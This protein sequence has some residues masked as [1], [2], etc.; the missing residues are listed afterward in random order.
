MVFHNPMQR[1]RVLHWLFGLVGLIAPMM[2]A[3]GQDRAEDGSRY[4]FSQE[5]AIPIVISAPHGGAINLKGVE[6]RNGEG[7]PQGASGFFAG[8][9]GGTEELAQEIAKE[10]EKRFG[11]PPFVVVS[12]VHRKYVD[13]NRPADLAYQHEKTKQ[14]Y[15]DYHGK[16]KDF[17]TKISSQYSAGLLLD[18]HGQGTSRETVYRGTKNGKSVEHL[19]NVFGEA[20]HTGEQSLFGSL[21]KRGWKVHPSPQDGKEQSGFTGG[22]ITVTYGSANF[23]L[24]DAMQL[25]FG[26]DYRNGDGRSNTASVLADAIVEYSRNY[27]KVDAIA[28]SNAPSKSM[29]EDTIKPSKTDGQIWVAVFEDKGVSSTKQL[30]QVLATDS[31]L[32]VKTLNAQ[33]IQNGELADVEVIIFPGGSGSGQ[34]K[35][36]EEQGREEVR[37]FLS[38]GGGMIG[39]CAGAYLAS[40]DYDWSLHVVDAKVI[41]RQHWNRGTGNVELD[42]SDQGRERFEQAS[43]RSTVYY[44]QG[45]LL[46]PAQKSDVPDYVPLAL[47]DT[48]I[49]KNG[50]PTGVMKGTAAIVQGEYGEGRTL[51][52]SPHPEKTNGQENLVLK[53]IHWVGR[54]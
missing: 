42:F 41:D 34:G 31:T 47:F 54:E 18:V 15:D 25:E 17:C 11:K 5:G 9:D 10:I 43:P 4:V 19:R 32:R 2:L 27:L 39:I 33:Q 35:A 13:M 8:R 26:A 37:K 30:H 51:C 12:R 1:K 22:F 40:C 24:M 46:A 21:A 23:P 7:L 36:L 29:V 38:R 6:P 45:P 52:F 49:A 53:A 44:H 50:A 14:I 20:A 16:L 28:K 48:E 3:H